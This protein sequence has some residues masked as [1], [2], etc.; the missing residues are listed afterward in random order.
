MFRNLI[1]LIEHTNTHSHV[2]HGTSKHA[3]KHLIEQP[4]MKDGDLG[5]GFYVVEMPDM[6]EDDDEDRVILEYKVSDNVRILDLTN[7]NDLRTWRHFEHHVHNPNL[8]KVLVEHGI[9]AVS[10]DSSEGVCF[11]NLDVLKFDR[12]YR[13]VI[14]DPLEETDTQELDEFA[15]G[16]LQRCTAVTVNALLNSFGLRPITINEVPINHPGVLYI[17]NK[18]GLAYKPVAQGAG[19]TVQQFI[20]THPLYDWYLLT[21]GHAM[22]LV[23]GELFDA[24]NKGADT[25][26]LEATFQIT[27]R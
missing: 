17:L 12:V 27:R 13:G 3:A 22:A 4:E 15:L 16:G 21:P 7:E 1:K 5:Y 2:W 24:E 14:D 25:R 20:S 23:K 26:Q 10:K 18:H 8:W 11:F 9:D 6:A 19:R